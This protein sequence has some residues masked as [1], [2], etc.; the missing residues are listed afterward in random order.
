MEK[1]IGFIGAGN[2][3][4]AL[5]TAACRGNDPKDVII[6]D[7]LLDKA[8]ALADKLGCCVASDN[9]EVV[10]S[11]HYIMLAVKP[12]V[13]NSVIKEINPV[14]K[15]CIETD[16]PRAL[17]SMA[18]GVTIENIKKKLD[19]ELP[20]IRI[21][22]NTPVSIGKGMILLTSNNK[23]AVVSEKDFDQF[24][25]IMNAAGKFDRISEEDMDAANVAMGCTP[26][27]AYM[28]IEALAD[29]AVMTGLPRDKAIKYAAQAV[30]GAAAMVIES[31]HHPG[32]LKDAVCS[33]GGSTIVG[34]A[35]LEKHGFRSAAIQAVLGAYNKTI[36]LGKN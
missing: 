26:A 8:K 2:M 32:I 13:L 4:S 30:L 11:A 31:R 10:R 36:D 25:S 9:V 28:F 1:K 20:I 5:I 14:L 12:Q 27:Y 7:Y 16:K 6:T 35:E 3:G 17:V 15:E 34:V 33:P 21:M 18:A 24:I 22:P 23:E 19:I 29:G